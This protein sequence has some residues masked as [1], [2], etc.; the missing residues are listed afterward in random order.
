[1]IKSF[2]HV[3]PAAVLAA[4]LASPAVAQGTSSITGTVTD[5]TG[6]V[7]P[8]ATVTV[9]GET[10]V[11]FT[12]VTNSQGVFTVPALSAGTYRVSVALQGF[13]T[14][15]FDKVQVVV[16]TPANLT[17]KLELGQLTEQVK[18]SSS[19]E[20]I[21]TQ[22]ATV[23]TT[24]NADQLNRMPTVSRNALNAVT[25]LPG[26]NTAT[27][28]RA[29]TV[30]G[31]PE[32]MINIT[33][34][35]V[36]N[37]DNFNKTTDGFFASVY[38][39]QDA[40]E[41]VTV[42][43]AAGELTGGGSGAVNIAF[44]TR[45]G[46]NRLSG[47]AYE[48]WRDPSLNTNYFFNEVNQLPK[49]DTKLNQ[50]GARIGGPLKIPGMYDGSG[51]AF[52]FF[53][54]EELRFP[55]SFTKT[56]TVHPDSVIQGIFPYVVGGVTHTKDLMALAAANGQISTFDPEIRQLLTLISNSTKT[57][58]VF[59]DSG[60]PLNRFYVWQSPATLL[61]RQPTGKFDYNVT[62]KHRFSMSASSLWATRDPDYLNNA[63]ARFAGA[64]NYR[65]FASTRPLYSFSLRST[66]SA[67]M[68]NELTAGLT[69]IGGGGSKFGQP[70]D[71]SQGTGSFADIGGYA[72]V[73][74]IAT[75]WWTV[76]S[77]SWR[78][79]PTYNLGTNLSWQK[80]SHSLSIGGGWLRSSAWEMSQQIVPQVNLDFIASADPAAG[81]FT[82]ANFPGISNGDL[83]NA[84]RI[85][86]ML[87][88]R[89]SSIQQV[90]ALDPDTNQYVL[91]GPRRREGYLD[92]WS[93]F[94]QDQWRV[95]P[96]LTIS[97]GARWDLQ[98]PF[99]ATNDVMA[100][101]TF[102]SICG[103]SGRGPAT[104]PY[105]KCNFFS[106][107][108]NTNV[109]PEFI[110]L[111]RGTRGYETDWNNVSPSVSVAWRPNVQSGF[112]RA[113]L[114]DPEQA[115]LRAGFSQTYSRQGLGV[116]TGQY[117]S[118]PGSTITVTRSNNNGNLVNAGETFPLLYSMKNR[119]Y[120]GTFPATQVFPTPI[121]ANRG[122][123]LNG[124]AD[125]VKI[126][127][128]RTWSMG[129][130]RAIT[131]DMAVDIRYVG[132]RGID[133]WSEL[134]YNA[135]D[136]I[137]NGFIDE[138]KLAVN[139]L[140]VNN[141]AGGNRAGS[142]A[143]FGANSGTS[144]LPVY[145]AHLQGAGNPA[146][147]GSYTSS[148]W[149]STSFTN[150]M[151][152][153]NPNPGNS[154][155][156]LD[157][158]NTFRNNAI[159]AGLPA[160]Y[161]VLNPAVDDVNVLDSGAY[162]EYHALQIEVRRRLSRGLSASGSYQYAR[163]GGSAFDGFLFGREMV[164]SAN[165]RHA[166]KTQWDWTLPVGRG[167]RFGADMNPW[168]DGLL[169][170]WSFKGVGRVQA[171]VLNFGNVR[172]VGMTADDLQKMYKYYTVE[173]AT[174]PLKSIY[175]LPEDVRQNTRAAFSFSSTNLN[176]YS[177]ALGAPTGRY[178]APANTENCL[179]LRAGDCAPRT[180]LI[181]APFFVRFDV[182][183]S[184]RFALKGASSIELSFEML[185][186]F[187]NI[188]FNPVANPGSGTDIFRVTSA[189]TDSSNTYD[190]GGRLGQ[191]MFRINW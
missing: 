15:V 149:R 4:L 171:R 76:N 138:F 127:S 20:L 173:N 150:D 119:L 135:L 112:L 68:V 47:S 147:S 101:V 36:S 51:K 48:Y 105:N 145:F 38:P 53:H 160:N 81:M 73:I 1:M 181:R 137:T 93:A 77:P 134:N 111:T 141:A 102:D 110:Q 140:K 132:T 115:T 186:V 66:L 80:A 130:Q 31:L 174:T 117:G 57:T 24:L 185:N 170:G 139:N 11:P 19:T 52:Y 136:F 8:G 99:T 34:D 89:V 44:T 50:Y 124:F 156:D 39:R 46:T 104:T 96:T 100:A 103:I 85:Y 6:G 128:A 29:S 166:I 84:R 158:S 79:A 184:K 94:L 70:A 12:A 162:S 157:G 21:N 163:E 114:G 122:S 37:Q 121:L 176:G 13:K 107:T 146:S 59:N 18:V 177:T 82:Q 26:V 98:T 179:Q 183:V 60:N 83:N 61:E 42:T 3:W 142:F 35:G 155:A 120:P 62:S 143:Y 14:A 58:G 106:R 55:N 5:S 71:P 25:F 161:F 92:V 144:P 9:T 164:A 125:D 41:Q 65:V 87:T 72:V 118:N 187:D 27:S 45:S 153:L 165:V 63:E 189:Y 133:Q 113:L 33:L 148:N 86:A 30:N 17:V 23:T 56:R 69:A 152:F 75:D 88:G 28:N 22:T 175:M 67:N 167:Q 123:D 169:G 95:K 108:T 129:F 178:I 126:D 16:G 97:G 32:S 188:N 159:A 78:A 151:V 40:V 172:L 54:Y 109:V 191:V 168:V 180:L 2:R 131:R 91:Q 10:G 182:G 43:L 116:F 49:N 154:A 64:P 190:P 90:A 74:P 7:I